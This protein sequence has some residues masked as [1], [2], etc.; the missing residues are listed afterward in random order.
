[1]S[2]LKEALDDWKEL[3]KKKQIF[4]IV[5]AAAGVIALGIHYLVNSK[6]VPESAETTSIE[7]PGTAVT[8]PGVQDSQK[9]HLSV[10]PTTNRNLGLEDMN[11]RLDQLE[12][13]IKHQN[14]DAAYL[15]PNKKNGVGLQTKS[16]PAVFPAPSYSGAAT[17]NL[18]KPLDL[19]KVD[20]NE[21]PKSQSKYS[22]TSTRD[23][24]DTPMVET[25]RPQPAEIQV[26]DSEKKVAQDNKA[27]DAPG[28]TIPV[29]SALDGV[30]L[31]GVNARQPGSSTGGAGTAVSALNVGAPFVTKLKGNAI[32]PNGW[33]LSELGDCFMGG[34][35]VAILST[36]RANA[37]SDTIS[38]IS[39]NGE[40][41]E[42]PV[43]AYALDVDGTL[44]IAG[45]VVSKQG[46]ILMQ[47]ALAGLASGLG[48]ALAPTAL[49]AYNSTASSGSTQG[50]QLPNA[51]LVAGT[52]VGQ[53]V[54]SAA[55]QLSR[56]YLEYA[57]EIFP[58]VEVVAGTRVTWILKES[59]EL[60]KI[61]NSKVSTK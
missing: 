41:W 42:A 50:Y 10:L 48:S 37:I 43:K 60:K 56:F 30:M 24:N 9:N 1:M 55:G 3:D 49:P 11:T 19:G 35:A 20:F 32:L 15:D 57:R 18:D 36:E 4:L 21:P 40:I 51:G 47:T 61:N 5:V 46:S 34:S 28:I 12:A 17:V 6:N 58:V 22:T 14:S 16:P 25:P 52:A 7:S 27:P 59:I 2:K 29:N 53:G 13:L 45:K 23:V 38:C 54:S 44:G 8:L 33:K 31:S 26:W 39:P